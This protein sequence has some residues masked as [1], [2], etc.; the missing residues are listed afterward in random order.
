MTSLE[1]LHQLSDRR[2][3]GMAAVMP[4]RYLLVCYLS[5]SSYFSALVS[6]QVHLDAHVSYS[7]VSHIH[8]IVLY[9]FLSSPKDGQVLIAHS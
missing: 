6:F 7:I 9:F 3:H 8:G 1:A 2:A 5:P 4:T